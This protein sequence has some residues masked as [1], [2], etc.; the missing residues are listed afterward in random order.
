MPLA[1]C[2]TPIGNLDDVTL[3]VLAELRAADT[4][5]PRTPG[6]RAACSSATG[7]AARLLSLPRAQ[8]GRARRRAPA[9]ARR[10]R[11]PRARHGRGAARRLRPGDA[12]RARGA[13]RGLDVTVLPGPVCRR[14]GSRRQRAG[15]RQYAFVGFLPRGEAALAALWRETARVGDDRGRLRVA[16]RLP[17][18]LR[19]LAEADPE[20]PVAVCRELTK[21]FEEVV[22]GTAG[23]LA[24]GSPSRRKARSRWS[25][26]RRRRTRSRRSRRRAGGRRRPGCRRNPSAGGR[27]GRLTV[28]GHVPK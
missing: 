4:S 10:R 28:H 1:V 22:R 23:E 21:R 15:R 20:R 24:G 7:S 19:S 2:A 17:A 6:T 9:A 8:R 5:S 16:K 11:A 12:P 14:D 26:R 3:R 25:S 13:R 18:T 27:R